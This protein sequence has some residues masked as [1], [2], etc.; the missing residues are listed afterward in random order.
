MKEAKLQVPIF[1]TEGI[2]IVILLRPFRGIKYIMEKTREKIIFAILTNKNIT[3][4]EL[5]VLTGISV[6]G[7]E[8]H[9]RKLK[10]E[11][12]IKRIGS[13]KNGHWE[14]AELFALDS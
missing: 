9:T 7:I 14:L 8:Y 3:T 10:S 2:F 1:K 12:I 5:S 11:K 4:Y 13:D 6:K